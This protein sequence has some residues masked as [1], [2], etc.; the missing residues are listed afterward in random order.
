MTTPKASNF[1]DSFDTNENLYEVHDGLRLTLLEDYSPGDT[2]IKWTGD[3]SVALKFP[4]TGII[5]LTEQCTEPAKDRA[6]SFHYGSIDFT[7]YTF[8]DIELLEEFEDLEKPKRITNITLNVMAVH[9]NTIK[10]ACIAIENFIGVKGTIDLV[11]F[12]ETLEGRINFLRKLVLVPRAWFTV[13]KRTGLVPLKVKFTDLSFRLATDSNE[14]PVV[15]IWDFGDNTTSSISMISQISVTDVVPVGKNNVLVNDLNG[16]AIEKT[17]TEP[18]IYDVTLTV[19]NDFGTDEIILPNLI[20]ARTE[21]PDLATINFAAKTSSQDITVQ[22][23]PLGGPYTTTTP[24]IRSPINTL[25]KIEIPDGQNIN[26]TDKDVSFAGELLDGSGNPVDPIVEYTWNLGDDITHNNSKITDASYG[27]GGV[28]DL[29]LRVDTQ[30]NSYRITSYENCFDIVENI[31]LWHWT[32]KSNSNTIINATEYG[33]LSETFKTTSTG[34]ITISR[35]DSFLDGVRE[36]EKQKIEFKKNTGFVPRGTIASGQQGTAFLYYASGRTSAE[37]ASAENIN[38]IEYNGFKLGQPTEYS[39]K[40]AISNKPW[41]WANLNI[42]TESYFIFGTSLDSIPPNQSPVNP[43]K[44]AYNLLSQTVTN[45]T[46]GASDFIN[47]A[48]ELLENVSEFATTADEPD[49]T[50]GESKY[51]DFSVYRTATREN[52]GYI[53]RNDGVGPFFRIRSFY[54]TEGT[55]GTPF[56]TIR[57]LE[58]ME[59]PTKLEGE[60]VNLSTG[61]FFINNSGSFSAYSPTTGVW[62]K[63]GPGINSASYRSL[64]DTSVQGFDDQSNT[65]LAA[66]DNDRRI[67]IS[68]D[69]S[70][71]AFIKFN[72]VDLT[73]TTLASRPQGEQFMMGIY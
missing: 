32:F 7:T 34:T 2:S 15:F 45:T 65:L 20:N 56:Q 63:G 66:S 61:L 17:Y 6:I 53:L 39:V 49:Y 9:H 21:A 1:P 22:G 5:T 8:E 3:L 52:T 41:N 24:V 26:V 28:Y 44:T 37:S 50:A 36:E 19:T 40:T 47:G 72:E 51:G 62:T 73:F 57:K 14:N 54:Q 10:D 31:N 59:G 30:F 35:D 18:G 4:A 70:P 27:I 46:F 60:L 38:V 55:I 69:Y 68:F 29:K 64:Q 11:P 58:D 33:L 25:I 42:G 48:E 71:N 23:L 16:G 67:Y 43:V 13:D 12:G